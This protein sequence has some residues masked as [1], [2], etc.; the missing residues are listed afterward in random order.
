MARHLV[1]RSPVALA[2]A[3]ALDAGAGPGAAGDVL[4]A[5]GARVVAADLEPD[6]AAF[7]A[8]PAV[9]A[10]VTALPF[11]ADSFDLAVA[12]FVVNHLADPVAGLTELRRVTRPG[13]AVL[14]STFSAD[15]AAAKA[16]VDR[17]ATAYGYV[18]PDWYAALKSY[19]HAFGEVTAVEQALG[20]AGFVDWTVSE[21]PLDVGLD[22][23]A[24]VVRY[25]LAMPQLHA[26]AATLPDETRAALVAEATDEVARTGERFAPIVIEAVA[27]A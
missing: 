10:D 25:R 15:R 2:G 19:E 9:A 7:G 12:A 20:A 27:I 21:R 24:D 26:F 8:R 23:P 13:G 22:D 4:R 17:V 14:A 18:A 3:F 1:D 5:R 16:T 6:M 11:R